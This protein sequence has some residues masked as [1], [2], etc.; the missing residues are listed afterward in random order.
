M[1]PGTWSL[2]LSPDTPQSILDAL[3]LSVAAFGHVI[4]TPAHLGT[5]AA[6]GDTLLSV[7]RYTGIITGRP[8]LFE[9]SGDG[10]PAWLGDADN[11]GDVIESPVAKVSGSFSAW[12]TDLVPSALSVGAVSTVAGALTQTFR[13]ISRREAL[14][15]VTD[16]F[17]SEWRVNPDGSVDA[18]PQA[19]LFVTD[20][21]AIVQRWEGGRDIDVTGLYGDVAV[22][23]D[24]EDWTTRVVLLSESG[25]G[26]ANISPAPVWRDLRGNVVKRTRIME[27]HET[28]PGNEAAVA[29]AQLNRF[30]AQRRAITLSSDQFDLGSDIA[31]GDT[32]WVWDPDQGLVDLSNQV[33][34][35]GRTVFPVA[36][37]VLGM[38]TPIQAGM[39]VYFRAPTVDGEIL[40]LTEWVEWESGAATI[41]IGAT[42]RRSSD[43]DTMSGVSG[44]V[45]P[46]SRVVA[47]RT[48]NQSIPNGTLTTVTFGQVL[49]DD[50]G[51]YSN[52]A[53]TA[54]EAGY[55]DLSAYVLWAGNSSGRR[56]LHF[57][58]NGSTEV[59]REA[60]AP[61]LAAQTGQSVDVRE[62]RLAAGD[63]VVVQAYH[64]AGG[65][66]AI[67]A[68]SV[69]ARFTVRRSR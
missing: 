36:I 1:R 8:S 41:E 22:A 32:I 25:V 15:F 14:D 35:R 13:W 43:E 48:S 17:G 56:Q 68:S 37:R 21:S 33:A 49:A 12:V 20:P 28:N 57:I 69:P 39:G 7:A 40:D 4:V 42:P 10:L 62:L 50:M 67:E 61:A 18:G 63:T 52:P 23:R 45:Q 54:P 27:S 6:S 30:T 2:S 9:L 31:V 3:D 34:Y 38:T 66:L 5:D 55:Y 44:V 58:L 64:N 26:A 29:Q 59:I 53:F 65:A 24:V 51:D 19:D 16:Y 47:Q 60:K 11:K 46:S